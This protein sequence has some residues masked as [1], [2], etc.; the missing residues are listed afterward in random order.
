MTFHDTSRDRHTDRPVIAIP[1]DRPLVV[2]PTERRDPGSTAAMQNP[3][4]GD[5]IPPLRPGSNPGLRSE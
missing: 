5:E 3:E 4:S 2:I 1:T